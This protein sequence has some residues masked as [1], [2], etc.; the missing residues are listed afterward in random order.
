V[1][2]SQAGF[3]Y[4]W[5]ITVPPLLPPLPAGSERRKT[6]LR[7]FTNRSKP[8]IYGCDNKL[9]CYM[10][11]NSYQRLLRPCR[12]VAGVGEEGRGT[13]VEGAVQYI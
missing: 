11:S 5:R 12:T 10:N 13:R 8:G 7:V 6:S 4:F 3:H 2:P 1:I 9:L